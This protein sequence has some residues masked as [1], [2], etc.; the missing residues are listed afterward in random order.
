[1]PS[2]GHATRK[3]QLPAVS[4]LRLRVAQVLTFIV[5]DRKIAG[6]LFA[7]SDPIIAAWGPIDSSGDLGYHTSNKGSGTIAWDTLTESPT[8]APTTAPTNGNDVFGS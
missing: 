3:G 7:A 6:R 5:K 1:M 2:D 8:G 4:S